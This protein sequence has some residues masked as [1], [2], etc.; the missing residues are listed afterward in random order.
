MESLPIGHLDIKD[1]KLSGSH[2]TPSNLAKFVAK[3]I[4]E[5]FAP[6][7][8]SK[9]IRILDPAIG[10]GELILSIIDEFIANNISN[11]EIFGFDT[12]N[13]ALEFSRSRIYQYYP[14]HLP[15][16]LLPPN[17]PEW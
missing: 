3:Q 17:R 11:I 1:R 4:F 5:S 13:N 12:D 2:Y 16:S 15:A 14:N 8:N 7:N 10:D 9:T 6:S